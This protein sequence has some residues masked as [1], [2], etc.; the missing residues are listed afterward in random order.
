M[1]RI[2]VR[3]LFGGETFTEEVQS[4]VTVKELT[5][6]S[7]TKLAKAGGDVGDAVFRLM[8]NVSFVFSYIHEFC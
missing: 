7:A 2:T 1:L 6:Y 4:S 5:A 3:A 8:C